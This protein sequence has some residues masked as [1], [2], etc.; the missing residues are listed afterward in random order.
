MMVIFSRIHKPVIKRAYTKH[1]QLTVFRYLIYFS[2][3]IDLLEIIQIMYRRSFDIHFTIMWFIYLHL[4][5][6]NITSNATH[7]LLNL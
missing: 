4:Y 5:Y 6:I 2:P 3:E 7:D 1:I